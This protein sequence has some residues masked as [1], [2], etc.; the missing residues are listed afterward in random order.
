MITLCIPID[1]RRKYF[2]SPA[3]ITLHEKSSLQLFL[4]GI[5][6]VAGIVVCIGSTEMHPETDKL[7]G[8]DAFFSQKMAEFEVPGAVT[9]RLVYMKKEI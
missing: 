3:L 7:D 6:F 9:L 4:L 1:R 5:C 2:S 8:F